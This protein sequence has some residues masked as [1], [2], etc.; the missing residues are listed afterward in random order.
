MQY[1]VWAESAIQFLTNVRFVISIIDIDTNL[2]PFGFTKSHFSAEN[3]HFGG[4][5]IHIGKDDLYFG[6][7][8]FRIGKE[9]SYLVQKYFI[10]IRSISWKCH[11]EGR[12]LREN[13]NSARK[14]AANKQTGDF[15]QQQ[16]SKKQ[17][18]EKSDSVRQFELC[19]T[20]GKE[21]KKEERNSHMFDCAWK[22]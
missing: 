9:N 19:K 7:E 5:K 16:N 18:F 17:Q 2:F 11:I 6:T 10:L 13:I 3:F 21:R 1:P 8:K 22:T 14:N 4:E 15:I 20:E 12:P